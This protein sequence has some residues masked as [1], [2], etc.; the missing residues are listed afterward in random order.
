MAPG[1]CKMTLLLF[2]GRFLSFTWICG[3]SLLASAA[4]VVLTPTSAA[5]SSAG[6]QEHGVVVIYHHVSAETPPVTSISPQQFR[7]HLDHIARHGHVVALSDMVNAIQNARPLPNN[8]IALTFDDA[9]RSVYEEALPLLQSRGWPF[10]IFVN[11]KAVGSPAHMNWDE[12]RDALSQG[13]EIGNHSWRHPHLV[14]RIPG[15]TESAWRIRVAKEI[16]QAQE[17]LTTQLGRR[18]KLFAFPYGEFNERL[19][20]L[21]SERSL[22]GFGQQSGAIDAGSDFLS[23]PRFALGGRYAGLDRLSL[24]LNVQPLHVADLRVDVDDGLTFSL[25]PGAYDESDF[26]CYAGAAGRMHMSQEAERIT[27]RPQ[28]K[29]APGRHKINCTA[30]G[31]EGGY[32]WWSHQLLKRRADG[33]WY[34]E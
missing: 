25:H 5:A 14:R 13:G 4:I 23:L 16:D 2:S 22:V 3:L 33:S 19:K 8:A 28:N 29:L 1:C 10:T 7:S 26:A 20:E 32:F 31:L 17:E 34:D 9:Y 6:L 18:P 21:V 27:V 24:L 11:T 12:L 15:E 30:P